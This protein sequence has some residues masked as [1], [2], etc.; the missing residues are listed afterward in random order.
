MKRD[1]GRVQ[2]PKY[3]S[4][5]RDTLRLRYPVLTL[6]DN[7]EV[8]K[9]FGKEQNRVTTGCFIY[10]KNAVVF[11]NY[12]QFCYTQGVSALCYP[13]YDTQN[14]SSTAHRFIPTVFMFKFS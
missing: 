10:V 6:W 14:I 5:K 8:R 1:T 11:Y 3:R 13:L 9:A 4:F 2:I 7:A 12:L